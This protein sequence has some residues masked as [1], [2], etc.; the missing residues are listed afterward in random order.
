LAERAVSQLLGLRVLL[1]RHGRQVEQAADHTRAIE[2]EL[3]APQHCVV[4]EDWKF[5]EQVSRLNARDVRRFAQ[6]IRNVT[7]EVKR[8]KA[9][10]YA[11]DRSLS[12]KMSEL[13]VPAHDR[14][15]AEMCNLIRAVTKLPP[16]EMW[17]EMI[18]KRPGDRVSAEVLAANPVRY[19]VLH[20][21]AHLTF[22]QCLAN[23]V[24]RD[25]PPSAAD[26]QLL[27]LFRTRYRGGEGAWYDNLIACTAQ[28][29]DLL[30]THDG[31]LER[32]C[33]WLRDLGLLRFRSTR[34]DRLIGS[35][36]V[37]RQ[38]SAR[39]STAFDEGITSQRSGSSSNGLAIRPLARKKQ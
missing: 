4:T 28:H 22:R 35:D 2:A 29:A 16:T 3:L 21:L 33:E 20:A 6:K 11:I 14:S 12:R 23:A 17:I 39:S 26:V 10:L 15:A 5:F 7:A 18:A 9:A 19:P 36:S 34:L 24:D 8:G 38:S 1:R 27:G 13:G 25:Q 30:V 31:Q 32:K 37:D